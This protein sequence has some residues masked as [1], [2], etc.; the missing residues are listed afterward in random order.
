[1]NNAAVLENT[2]LRVHLL[3]QLFYLNNGL[4]GRGGKGRGWILRGIVLTTRK[5]RREKSPPSPPRR[6]NLFPLQFRQYNARVKILPELYNRAHPPFYFFLSVFG[7][8]EATYAMYVFH[9]GPYIAPP[10]VYVCTCAML[11]SNVCYL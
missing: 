5:Q 4:E 8:I 10:C 6:D 3:A 2:I 7:E 9:P 11:Y 1:M